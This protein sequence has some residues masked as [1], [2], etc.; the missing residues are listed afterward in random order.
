MRRLKVKRLVAG[1]LFSISAGFSA[2]YCADTGFY[3]SSQSLCDAVCTN[4]CET[5]LDNPQGLS[6][7]T[8]DYEFF[9]YN[10]QTNKTIAVT[11]NADF[12]DQFTNLLVIED[13]SDNEAGRQLAQ[14]VNSS[15]WIGMHD[16]NL[17]SSYN[18]IN[19][20]RFVWWDGTQ[21]SY[22]NWASGEPDNAVLTGDIGVVNP[23]GEH[24]AFTGTDGKWRDD[25]LHASRG[26]DYKPRYRALVMWR[27]Q[28]DCVNG[29]SQNDQTTTTDMVNLY[30]NGETPCFLCTDGND[31]QRCS[32]NTSL[33][34]IQKA[35]CDPSC[36]IGY[37]YVDVHQRCEA[38]PVITCSGGGSLSGGVCVVD[39][40]I[41][42][43]QGGSYNAQ[44]GKCEAQPI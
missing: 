38:S 32:P 20:G 34:P 10:P 25:G 3:Y 4:T 42:C 28:L 43:P 24:W 22:T 29:L 17:S 19:P 5:L 11:K 8:T 14:F 7:D 23:P 6:C 41:N 12:W 36:P 21:V 27:K 13:A 39:P 1:I 16:P 15:L 44:T 2:F 18:S 31:I 9:I 37:V 26:G 33:C 35:T 40:T 30:C